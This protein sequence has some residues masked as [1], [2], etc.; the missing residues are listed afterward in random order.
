MKTTR[1]IVMLMAAAMSIFV[2]CDKEDET[3]SDNLNETEKM[4]VGSW[5]E[6]ESLY[7]FTQGGISD[8][9]SML[10]EGESVVMTFNSDKTY[11]SV[12]HSLDGDDTDSGNWSASG[13]K[14][15]FSTM[16]GPVAYTIHQLDASVFNISYNE[17]GEDE[18]GY[19]TLSMV[20]SMT[21][22]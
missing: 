11:T 12:Y 3:P 22:L 13:D 14:L 18:D 19:Y 5:N 1:F 10:E 2:S 9:T 15:T 4:I 20:I 8:T 17:E 21:K 16:M 6:T 7:I